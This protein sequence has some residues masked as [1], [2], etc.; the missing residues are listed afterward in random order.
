LVV[1]DELLLALLTQDLL[2]ELGCGILG[3][4][5]SMANALNL[6]GTG[7]FDLAVLDINLA[8]EKVCPV[9]G[10][11]AARRIPF[12]F[13]SGYGDE[14]IP[15]GRGEWKICAKPFR[16]DDL[17]TMMSSAGESPAR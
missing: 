14:A 4:R 17:A 15:P 12:L 11:P 16:D 8:G 10:V 7:T 1:E 2:G 9:V 13:L 3:L 6:A 5:A